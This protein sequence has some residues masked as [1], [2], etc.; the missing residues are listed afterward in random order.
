[1]RQLNPASSPATRRKTSAEPEIIDGEII[2]ERPSQPRESPPRRE[3]ALVLAPTPR[4]DPQAQL[5]QLPPEFD[6][7]ALVASQRQLLE[8]MMATLEG[9]G[10]QG[11]PAGPVEEPVLDSPEVF[12][13]RAMSILDD[14][15]VAMEATLDRIV[16]NRRSPPDAK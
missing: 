6:P 10:R 3:V 12:L 9:R 8:N 15:V 2:D 5:F 13:N 14:H 16:G 4:P 11:A 7:E 1:M